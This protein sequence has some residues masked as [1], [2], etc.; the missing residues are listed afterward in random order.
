MYCVNNTEQCAQDTKGFPSLP[1]NL[2]GAK[3]PFCRSPMVQLF[4]LDPF[5]STEL[6]IGYAT[7]KIYYPDVPKL[8]GGCEW[9]RAFS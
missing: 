4:Y 9:L 8:D 1:L 6:V 3:Q 5:S 7:R 2:F